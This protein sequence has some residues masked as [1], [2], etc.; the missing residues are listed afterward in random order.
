LYPRSGMMIGD[1]Y[2]ARVQLGFLF[3]GIPEREKEFALAE[4]VLA[5]IRARRFSALGALLLACA[6]ASAAQGT[7]Q[8]SASGNST[9]EAASNASPTKTSAGKS[10]THAAA[11]HKRPTSRR[12]KNVRARGQQK[13]DS[14][15]SQ[16]I[17]EALIREHYLTGEANGKWNQA[18]EDAMRRYQADNGWQSKTVPDS[19]ALIKLGLGPSHDHLLN[20]ESAMTTGPVAPHAAPATPAPHSPDPGT[21]VNPSTTAP[22]DSPPVDPRPT[23]APGHDASGPQ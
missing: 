19:R 2:N 17:Q 8:T 15:R 10:N 14:E 11:S 18:C 1:D 4:K 16:A 20:P 12:K 6:V 23:Q 22:V 7:P 21:R 9:S 3:S 13:I 5:G